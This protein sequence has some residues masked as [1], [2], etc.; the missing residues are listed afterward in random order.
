MPSVWDKVATFALRVGKPSEGVSLRDRLRD[1][2]RDFEASDW[3]VQ[4]LLRECA[5]VS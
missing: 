5:L 4:L 3:S 2:L 1:V